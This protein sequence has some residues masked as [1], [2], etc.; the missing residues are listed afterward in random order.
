M[1]EID[2]TGYAELLAQAKR[3]IHAARVRAALVVNTELIGLYWRLGRLI[4]DR[5]RAEGWGAKVIDR[6]SAALRAEFPGTRGLSVS[7]LKY[8]RRFAE[9]WPDG[10]IGQRVVDQLP[11]GHNIELLAGP[12]TPDER[13][14]YAE[15]ALK[16]AWSRD[17]LA[18]NIRSRLHA[19]VGAAS[20]NFAVTL[21][22]GDS[23]LFRELLKDPYHLDFLGLADEATERDLER[24]LIAHVE[25]FLLELGQGFAFVGRQ[26]PLA[27]GGE[28][29]FIDLLFFHIPTKR[30]LVLELKWKRFVPEAVGKLN[31]YVNA[32]DD[33]L[34]GGGENP[35]LGLLLCRTRNEVVVRYALS[36][37]ATPLAVAGYRLAELPPDARQS[38]P[39][40]DV[41]VGAVR[42]ADDDGREEA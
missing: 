36:G 19:R 23:A 38:L 1:S 15:Q 40:E 25:R 29:F 21:P 42:A 20:T 28:D 22:Q 37:V 9:A 41:L 18:A 24:A 14:W 12:P 31:C 2:V 33:M 13:R 39:G 5:Q 16:R 7:N 4:L 6:L 27:V 11:W 10:E 8:M 26:Y 35:T 30:Y 32:V 34:R 3:Q 17:V